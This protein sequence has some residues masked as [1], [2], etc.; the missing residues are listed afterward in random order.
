[1]CWPSPQTN[2][3]ADPITSCGV[4]MQSH[5]AC[6]ALPGSAF[7]PG[8][9]AKENVFTTGRSFMAGKKMDGAMDC[10]CGAASK[11]NQSMPTTGFMRPRIKR[12]CKHWYA[13]PDNA[14]RSSK[15]SRP[16]R[17]SAG[18]TI[19]KSA[20]GKAGIGTLPWPCWPTRF[21]SYC[22]HEEKKLQPGRYRSASPN[23]ATCPP[24]FSGANGTALS[25]FST[26][27]DGE[28]GTSFMLCA[29]TTESADRRS[30]S[31]IYNCSTRQKQ[32]FLSPK[33]GIHRLHRSVYCS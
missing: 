32:G 10:W 29:A 3:C 17:A 4:W 18:W 13:W 12:P 33:G 11:S 6:Q 30:Q 22:A 14:G 23:Y 7:P 25:I 5:R 8:W 31:S 9:A 15:P 27:R 21:S 19:T 16:P 2:V 28:D 24:T 20:T 26:G 1:M